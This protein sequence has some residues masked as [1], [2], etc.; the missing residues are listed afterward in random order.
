MPQQLRTS[1][2]HMSD[3]YRATRG[4]EYRHR[5]GRTGTEEGRIRMSM[6]GGG[7]SAGSVSCGTPPETTSIEQCRWTR[8]FTPRLPNAR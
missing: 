4:A 5:G 1:V 7:W 2:N 6:R 3:V 8:V